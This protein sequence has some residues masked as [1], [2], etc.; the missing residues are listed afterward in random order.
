MPFDGGRVDVH[1]HIAPPFWKKSAVAADPHVAYIADWSE[2]DTLRTMDA[3]GTRVAMLSLTSPGAQFQDVRTA[4][5]LARAVNEYGAEAVRRRPDRF[6][7]LAC[8]PL[9]DPDAAVAEAV[10]ALDE[11]GA[12]GVAVLSNAGGRYLGD[13]AYR[14][15]WEALDRRGAVVLVH[16][17]SPQGLTDLPGLQGWAEWPFDTT[18]T[19]L[20]MVVNGV[21][22]DHPSLKVILSHAGGFLPYQV[23][24]FEELSVTNPSVTRE[25]VR[26][27][28]RRFYFDTALTTHPATLAALLAF[29]GAGHVLFGT[30]MPA[31]PLTV[32]GSL[33]AELDAHLRET[34]DVAYGINMGTAE[35]IFGRTF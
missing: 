12:D 24:R 35:K 7:L 29:A 27:D 4:N 14:P 31:A 1:Q 9:L 6:G 19:A 20:H 33:A 21:M 26:E 10:Y 13:H 11:L 34:P 5:A 3:L 28:L 17:T 15:L 8:L 25:G 30:D 23:T 22:R 18:R 2:A 32:A 16:P